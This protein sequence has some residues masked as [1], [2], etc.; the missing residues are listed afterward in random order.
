[1]VVADIGGG[2]AGRK[3]GGGKLGE[4]GR[5]A[6]AR[7]PEIEAQAPIVGDEGAQQ[8]DECRTEKA[9]RRAEADE[10]DRVGPGGDLGRND[11]GRVARA[12]TVAVTERFQIERYSHVMH[13]VSNVRGTLAAGRDCFDA[14]RAAFPAGT[15][16]G[17]PKIRAMEIIEELEP[18]RRGVYGGAVGYFAFSG[19]MDTAI[20]IR[21]VL[22]RGG[23][24]YI[25][26]GAGIV[27]DSNPEAEH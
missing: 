18:V 5:L 27:A 19:A 25:Q 2:A 13:L 20:T 24:L 8:A 22:F 15:L 14:F 12:G 23:R 4:H 7:E 11:V 10:R 21:F 3:S 9:V 1:M 26:A 17:A 16:T 6:I